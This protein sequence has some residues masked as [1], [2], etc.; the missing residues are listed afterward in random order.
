WK[1][2]RKVPSKYVQTDGGSERFIFYEATAL[3]EPTVTATVDEDKVNIGNADGAE[4]GPVVVIINDGEARRWTYVEKVDSKATV[5]VRKDAFQDDENF[6]AALLDACRRQ[7]QAYG[8]TKEEATAI[9]DVW[10]T[11]LLQTKGFLLIS[12][13]PETYYRAM[14]PLSIT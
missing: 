14:F 9:V 5:S 8:M 7:W 11:E 2:A 12:R 4:S 10:K 3:Q 13:M 6:S 1:I